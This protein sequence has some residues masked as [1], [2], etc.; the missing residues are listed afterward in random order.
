MRL[1]PFLRRIFLVGR[2]MLCCSWR[3]IIFYFGIC[4]RML[5]FGKRRRLAGTYGKCWNTWDLRMRI[6]GTCV[7]RR[8]GDW[9]FAVH[10]GFMSRISLTTQF[11]T[12]CITGGLVGQSVTFKTLYMNLKLEIVQWE[13]RCSLT[14]ASCRS[15]NKIYRTLLRLVIILKA[16]LKLWQSF[17]QQRLG[18]MVLLD[19]KKRIKVL[20]SLFAVFVLF[21]YKYSY[22]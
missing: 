21:F 13:S 14:P 17:P 19:E 11:Q 16:E 8:R 2:H 3:F 12:L 1:I 10:E 4:E 22:F 15:R 9:T 18:G 20:R 7:I 5:L 6:Q